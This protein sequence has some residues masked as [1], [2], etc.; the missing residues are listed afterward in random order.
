WYNSK[1]L[2][3]QGRF[4]F[5]ALIPIG[6]AAALGLNQLAGLLPQK[7]RAWTLSGLFGGMALF[8]VYCLFKV[9]VPFL[10]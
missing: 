5:P 2:H 9:V 3:H 4:L 7:V 8:A 1:V 10:S 6:T